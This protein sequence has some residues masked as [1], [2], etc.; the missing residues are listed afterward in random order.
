[1][2]ITKKT[3]VCLRFF[4][5]LFFF[6]LLSVFS[7]ISAADLRKGETVD[8][9]ETIKEDLYAGGGEVNLK[10]SVAGDANV[11][12]GKGTVSL[13][14]DRDL[15]IAGG[16][17]RLDSRVGD[18]LHVF[19]GEVEINGV[20]GGDVFIV[21]GDVTIG[22]E[23]KIA[24]DVF[25]LAGYLKV[26]GAINGSL[27]VLGGNVIANGIIGKDFKLRASESSI[28]GVVGGNASL[29]AKTLVI[30]DKA[31]FEKSVEYGSGNEVDFKNSVVN[32]KAVINPELIQDEK[33]YW[34][35][36]PFFGIILLAWVLLVMFLL[37]R[38][39]G[40]FLKESSQYLQKNFI[41]GFGT[42]VLY[43][44]GLP[45]LMIVLTA[46]LF[47]IPFAVVLCCLYTI[48]IIFARPAT[49]VILS[50]LIQERTGKTWNFARQYLVSLGLYVLLFIT[51]HI[52]F[53]G[54]AITALAVGAS[55]GSALQT[56]W[57]KRQTA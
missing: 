7:T 20:I 21:G 28:G 45:V 10:G 53:I 19:A 24:G 2:Q 18:D 56:A 50:Y 1:M 51:G 29:S 31:R 48:S 40:Q 25:V 37:N 16:D 33:P 55:F 39:L 46:L 4:S 11:I 27:N 13:K 57:A 47:T 17:F 5:S 49:A 22:K 34:I 23:A 8:M 42:G 44:I 54:W 36:L 26:Y 38:Y 6:V 32:G 43:F 52:P 14:V 41:T 3:N 12:G 35:L 30:G 15:N 9:D